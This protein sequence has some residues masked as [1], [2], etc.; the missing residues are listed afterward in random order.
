MD[1]LDMDEPMEHLPHRVDRRPPGL[2]LDDLG[3]TAIVPQRLRLE[4]AAIEAI[5]ELMDR[6]G[7]PAVV[8]DRKLGQA[9]RPRL[10]LAEHGLGWIV[11]EIEGVLAGRRQEQVERL[12]PPAIEVLTLV[13]D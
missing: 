2:G 5:G 13:H 3:L 10:V 7:V 9:E 12:E 8:F 1:A 6:T 4:A 11:E